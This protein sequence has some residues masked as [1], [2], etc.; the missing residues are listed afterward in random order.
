MWS[1][2]CIFFECLLCLLNGSVDELSAQQEGSGAD[3]GATRGATTRSRASS[4][5]SATAATAS[6]AASSAAAGTTGRRR[7]AGSKCRPLFPGRSCFALSPTTGA[8]DDAESHDQVGGG[9]GSL[10]GG[11]TQRILETLPSS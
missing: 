6:T 11:A 9:G 7:R 8:T 10:H 2:G 1:A 3:S 5:R 4:A